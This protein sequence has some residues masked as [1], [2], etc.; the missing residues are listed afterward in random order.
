[1]ILGLAGYA[2]SG[3]D[4]VGRYLVE[5]HGFT[6]LAFAD[7]LKRFALA[8]NP[9]VFASDDGEQMRLYDVLEES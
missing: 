7:T 5:E 8:V 6:R 4:T 9:I 3:K 1:M 2:T